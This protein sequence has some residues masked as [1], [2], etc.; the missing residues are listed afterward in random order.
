MKY[1]IDRQKKVEIANEIATV[2]MR[3]CKEMVAVYVFGSFVTDKPFSDIDI[4]I[5]FREANEKT[6]NAELNLESKIEKVIKF[7]MDV[8]ILNTAPLSFVRNVIKN[9]RLIVDIDPT[10]R[11]DF[12]SLTA[13]KYFDFSRFRKRYLEDVRNAPI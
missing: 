7:Q 10:F 6:L 1:S 13:K 12:E 4:G 8:R 5:L 9:G 3:H 11:S 2:L